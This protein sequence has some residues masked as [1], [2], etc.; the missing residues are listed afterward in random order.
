MNNMQHDSLKS[1]SL[2]STPSLMRFARAWKFWSHSFYQTDLDYTLKQ[3]PREGFI[4]IYAIT[5]MCYSHFQFSVRSCSSLN[6]RW[7]Y[8]SAGYGGHALGHIISLAADM[9][10]QMLCVACM[11]NARVCQSLTH[12]HFASFFQELSLPRSKLSQVLVAVK[13]LGYSSQVQ[14]YLVKSFRESC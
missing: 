8:A 9:T 4:W 14:L 13:S 3:M 10:I 11:H 7:G 5:G 1:W 12:W 2:L 6:V